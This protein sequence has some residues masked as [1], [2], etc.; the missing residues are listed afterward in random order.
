M[1][2][3]VFSPY[4]GLFSFIENGRVGLGDFNPIPSSFKQ[5]LLNRLDILSLALAI[6]YDDYIDPSDFVGEQVRPKHVQRL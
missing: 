5:S 1:R 4:I 2:A 6:R 3:E